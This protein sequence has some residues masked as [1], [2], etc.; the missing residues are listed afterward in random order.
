[1][2][3]NLTFSCLI[4]STVSLLVSLNQNESN[5]G[6][7]IDF[8]LLFITKVLEKTNRQFIII[9]NNKIN[10]YKQNLVDSSCY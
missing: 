3:L 8:S 6:V 5:I 7:T 4:T 10:M 9:N 1:M 2:I